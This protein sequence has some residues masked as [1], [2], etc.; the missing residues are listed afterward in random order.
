METE[1]NGQ[2]I[3]LASS[4]AEV[5]GNSTSDDADGTSGLKRRRKPS[6]KVLELQEQKAWKHQ[7]GSSPLVDHGNSRT[8]LE[9][10]IKR[11]SAAAV[12][13]ENMGD[14]VETIERRHGGEERR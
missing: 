10:I 13:T 6:A 8:N 14:K 11:S 3:L 9:R 12:T 7:R 5:V 2:A 4:P 1:Q